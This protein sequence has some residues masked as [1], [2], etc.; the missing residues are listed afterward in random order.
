MGSIVDTHLKLMCGVTNMFTVQEEE[1][2]MWSVLTYCTFK[3]ISAKNILKRC[4]S[5]ELVC[6]VLISF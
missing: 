6:L 1:S 2:D 3:G 4:E 5:F